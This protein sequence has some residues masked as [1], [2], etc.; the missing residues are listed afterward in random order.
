MAERKWMLVVQHT[1]HRH[2]K[3]RDQL[4]EEKVH[5]ELYEEDSDQLELGDRKVHQQEAETPYSPN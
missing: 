1:E 3:P 2:H 4:R 5:V